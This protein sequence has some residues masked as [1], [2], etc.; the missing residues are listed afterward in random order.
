[1]FI[2]LNHKTLADQTPSTIKPTTYP[3]GPAT[4]SAG[5]T[6]PVY[7][8]S[9]S[10]SVTYP[11]YTASS[12]GVSY[13]TYPG[14]TMMTSTTSWSSSS[15]SASSTTSGSTTPTPSPPATVGKFDFIGCLGSTDG[16]PTFSLIESS[17]VMSVELCTTEC[18]ASGFNYAG[19]YTTDCY[20]ASSLDDATGTDK[21]NGVCDLPCPGNQLETCGGNAISSP[22]LRNR[23]I[24]NAILLDLYECPTPTSTTSTSS[25]ESATSS[26][27]PNPSSDPDPQPEP[28]NINAD[29]EPSTLVKARDDG[30]M[31]RGG[32]LRNANKVVKGPAL[33]KRDYGLKKNS[34]T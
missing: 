21:T 12:G 13:P 27:T 2:I 34:L 25:T 1:M 3:T 9:T 8:V 17:G 6:Y 11:T 28:R 30:K 23:A 4:V 22:K 19:L 26:S 16:F 24:T 7:P 29:M 18:L 32:M 33:A 10:A 31:R 14:S 15:G 5:S 20:C